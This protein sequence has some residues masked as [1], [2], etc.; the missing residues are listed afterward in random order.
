MDFFEAL[1]V[2]DHVL[3]PGWDVRI[4]GPVETKENQFNYLGA[5]LKVS[6]CRKISAQITQLPV[7]K[8]LF[9][10][11]KD[12]LK[13]P[14]ALLELSPILLTEYL[15]QL[16]HGLQPLIFNAI[17]ILQ[18][19]YLLKLIHNRRPQLEAIKLQSSINSVLHEDVL[20]IILNQILI[21]LRQ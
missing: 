8:L 1:L 18:L 11:S 20:R 19:I 12:L 10:D 6:N 4:I 5:D 14:V 2:D 21:Q 17:S 3:S 9:E 15:H 7:L 13:V 16:L